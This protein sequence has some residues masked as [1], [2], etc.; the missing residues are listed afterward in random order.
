MDTEAALTFASKMVPEGMSADVGEEPVILARN[1]PGSQVCCDVLTQPRLAPGGTDVC[2][3]ALKAQN[4][5]PSSSV[6]PCT[7]ANPTWV[8]LSLTSRAMTPTLDMQ[9]NTK[10]SGI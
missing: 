6:G 2:G 10:P 3:Q 1:Q 4:R 5:A 9:K 8:G 7:A